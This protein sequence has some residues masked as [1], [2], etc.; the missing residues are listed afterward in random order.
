LSGIR[1]FFYEVKK[2]FLALPDLLAGKMM[3]AVTKNISRFKPVQVFKVSVDC[4]HQG[5]RAHVIVKCRTEK[6]DRYEGLFRPLGF[7]SKSRIAA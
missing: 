6:P 2:K 3:W 7:L 1:V 4:K 5:C